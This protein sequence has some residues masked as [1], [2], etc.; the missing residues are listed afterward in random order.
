VTALIAHDVRFTVVCPPCS[1][2]EYLRLPNVTIKPFLR[3]AS[4]KDLTIAERVMNMDLLE[5]LGAEVDLIWTIDEALPIQ[6]GKPVVLSVLTIAYREEIDAVLSANWD[7]AICASQYLCEI[8]SF[9][10]QADQG[11]ISRVK[12][13]T[14]SLDFQHFRP[15][16]SREMRAS[17]GLGSEARCLLFPHRP[18]PEKGFDDALQVITALHRE[19][20]RWRLMIPTRPMAAEQNAKRHADFYSRLKSDVTASGLEEA[21]V[22]HEWVSLDDMPAYLSLGEFTLVP[23]RLPEGFG[24]IPLQS[25]ACGTPVI[26]TTCGALGG[27]Y[28]SGHGVVFTRP[29]DWQSIVEAIRVGLPVKEAEKGRLY[30]LKNYRFD[31]CVKEHLTA[32]EEAMGPKFSKRNFPIRRERLAV[33]PWIRLHENDAWHDFNM[34]FIET[35]PSE[36]VAL[37]RIRNAD[38][39]VSP[40]MVKQLCKKELLVRT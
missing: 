28:P 4:R 29:G 19:D 24:Y 35:S 17:L 8:V 5:K 27:K 37:E 40:E 2:L 33:P 3:E 20:P 23:S 13:A 9:V 36:R 32:F 34:E 1:S 18:E 10:V 11:P 15:V 25:I 16:D 12:T 6:S 31:L 21:V 14:L 26:S 39:E 22:F 30:S 7:V 38:F